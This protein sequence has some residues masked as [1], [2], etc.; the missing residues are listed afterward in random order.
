MI[1]LGIFLILIASGLMGRLLDSWEIRESSAFM[2][3]LLILGG[4]FIAPINIA[5][6]VIVSIGGFIIPMIVFIWMLFRAKRYEIVRTI[7]AALVIGIVSGIL[8]FNFPLDA[9]AALIETSLLIGIIAGGIAFLIGRTRRGAFISAGI[10]VL[11]TNIFIFLY[12]LIIGINIPILLGTGNQFT[13]M[14]IAV[15]TAVFVAEVAGEVLEYAKEGKTDVRFLNIDD[16][17]NKVE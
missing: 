10:G 8:A 3:C 5:D 1:I 17:V 9:E 11:F 13:A 2:V 15:I 14:I 12:M 6:S 7:V 4:L 16:Y